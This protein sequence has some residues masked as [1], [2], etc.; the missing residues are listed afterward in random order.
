MS[1]FHK[2]E[3]YQWVSSM[4]LKRYSFVKSRSWGT[5]GLYDVYGVCESNSPER[6]FLRLLI[7]QYF[8]MRIT[9][10][11]LF[12]NALPQGVTAVMHLWYK[13]GYIIAQCFL[14]EGWDWGWGWGVGISREEPRIVGLASAFP[15]NLR[16]GHGA[17]SW[18]SC[19]GSRLL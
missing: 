19:L 2:V 15:T 1:L 12:R 6:H 5:T 9:W 17:G 16:E 4:Y 3:S 14:L 7:L 13:D 11:N 10:G 8:K 18:V